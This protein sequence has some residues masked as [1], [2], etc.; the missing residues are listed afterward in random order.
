[1]HMLKSNY[2]QQ[3]GDIC[4]YN[5]I[6]NK[7]KYIDVQSVDDKPDEVLQ[8]CEKDTSTWD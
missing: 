4:M 1:M 8:D 2:K 3:K 5:N 6:K 7:E